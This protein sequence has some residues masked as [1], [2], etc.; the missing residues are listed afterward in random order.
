MGFDIF[1]SPK[2]IFRLKIPV[3]GERTTGYSGSLKKLV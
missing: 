1:M 2:L 3:G